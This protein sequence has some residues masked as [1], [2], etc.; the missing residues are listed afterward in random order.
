MNNNLN[1]DLLKQDV[2]KEIRE[3]GFENLYYALF[4]EHSSQLWAIHLYYQDGKFMVNSR[5]D[6][7]YIMGKTREFDNFE[8]AKL[9][10]L[11]LMESF[12]EMNRYFVQNGD[13]PY[14][15]CSLWDEKG[16]D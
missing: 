7:T 10:F 13:S 16:D 9:F 4:D 8:E 6:R 5:D 3:K 2:E 14:Y 15:S 12:I 11:N 1:L